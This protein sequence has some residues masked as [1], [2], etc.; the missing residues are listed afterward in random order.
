MSVEH[1]HTFFSAQ[2]EK[3]EFGRY[4]ETAHE[5]LAA[6]EPFCGCWFSEYSLPTQRT[7]GKGC[8]LQ[9]L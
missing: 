7:T 9:H 1:F 6:Q 3:W 2:A 5:W 4:M 8:F